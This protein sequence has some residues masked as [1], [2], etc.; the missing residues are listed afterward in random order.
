MPPNLPLAA[1]LSILRMRVGGLM[2]CLGPRTVV[3][4][5]ALMQALLPHLHIYHTCVQT[6]DWSV[7]APLPACSAVYD[8]VGDLWYSGRRADGSCGAVTVCRGGLEGAACQQVV[9]WGLLKLMRG[10]AQIQPGR[11]CACH[12]S[13]DVEA[14]AHLWLNT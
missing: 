6:G 12:T 1:L 14:C 13:D 7:K 4:L 3:S 10:A 11:I 9:L 8:G 2:A 5:P